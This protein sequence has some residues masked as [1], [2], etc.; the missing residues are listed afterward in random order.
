MAACATLLPGETK[1]VLVKLDSG[2]SGVTFATVDS[3]DKLTIRAALY[4]TSTDGTVF[5]SVSNESEFGLHYDV[6]DALAE[7]DEV[8]KEDPQPLSGIPQHELQAMIATL[9]PDEQQVAASFIAM[10]QA[11]VSGDTTQAQGGNEAEIH[12]AIGDPSSVSGTTTSGTRVPQ[13]IAL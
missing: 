6:G 7:A 10:Q 5:I 9:A 11:R 4:E 2:E 8:R 13:P 1:Q 3:G 12:A